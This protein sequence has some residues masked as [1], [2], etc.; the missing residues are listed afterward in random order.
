MSRRGDPKR[1]LRLSA[2]AC[3]RERVRSAFSFRGTRYLVDNSIVALRAIL[4]WM[5]A[6][7]L[8][9]QATIAFSTASTAAGQFD[10]TSAAIIC[11]SSADGSPITLDPAA[12]TCP[13]CIV[14]VLGHSLPHAQTD[15]LALPLFTSSYVLSGRQHPVLVRAVAHELPTARGPP[16]TA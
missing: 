3:L 9:L 5:A 12:K 7:G 1:S 11:H 14:C 16:A 8:I 4:V 15:G 2:F 6:W 13:Q 10:A